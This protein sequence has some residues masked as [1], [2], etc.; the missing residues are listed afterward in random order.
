MPLSQRHAEFRLRRYSRLPRGH[1]TIPP[2]NLSINSAANSAV[3]F[4][5][6]WNTN[7]EV[8]LSKTK[9]TSILRSAHDDSARPFSEKWVQ[10]ISDLSVECV[11]SKIQTHIA[12]LAT[13]IL[14]RAVD[15]KLDLRAVKPT[16]AKG[17]QNAYSARSLCHSIIVPV[18]NELD[19]H[20]GVSGR[21]PLNNQPYF[22]MRYLGDETPVHSS[23]ERG[24]AL[25]QAMVDD[26]QGVDS[27]EAFEALRAFIHVRKA[28]LPSYALLT[29]S[30]V[31]FADVAH[32]LRE[33]IQDQSENG[34]RAQ[35]VIA[36]IYDA[37]YGP[38]NVISGKIND[39]SRNLPGD[40]QVRGV[41]GNCVVA[42]EV[43]DK[44]VHL[45]DVTIFG[46]RCARQNI[47]QAI[48][49]GISAA[50]P[51][52]QDALID[53][54]FI[55]IGLDVQVVHTIDDILKPAWRWSRK[56]KSNF[57]DDLLLNLEKRLVDVEASEG[58]ISV[59]N[60]LLERLA[61]ETRNLAI[62][63]PLS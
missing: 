5:T 13:A 12:F 38:D 47:P 55:K 20:L 59:L 32:A 57:V 22:R 7:R 25:T 46:R 62:K 40:V 16:H 29:S 37:A 26:L 14:A 30:R 23:S 39:P 54:R 34:K 19:I 49:A 42:V 45:S 27:K 35:A 31:L 60:A 36:A 50:Q 52:D 9:A 6:F 48:V 4:Q 2:Y 63:R 1:P 15:D 8:T 43:R 17:N 61:P 51:T 58:S 28:Y 3:D 21:E 11:R 41:D 18:A 53:P 56:T 10:K 44:Q 24:F 33:L